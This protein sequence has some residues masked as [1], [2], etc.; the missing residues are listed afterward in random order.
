TGQTINKAGTVTTVTSAP[1][2]SVFGQPVVLTA[3]LVALAPGAGNP[4]GK[5]T[6]WDGAVGTGGNLGTGN[7][8]TTAGVTTATITVSTLSV[9]SHTINASYG[10][11]A[12]FL[13]SN[14]SLAGSA[15]QV[16]N[17]DTTTPTVTSSVNPSVKGQAV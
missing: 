16:V 1:S 10:G 6:F 12:N 11:D 17:K 9:A 5:V 2:P 13:V 7:L 3:T 8:S 15:T 14:T 4:T